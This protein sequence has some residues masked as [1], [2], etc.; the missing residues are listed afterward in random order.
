MHW[1]LLLI[2]AGLVTLIV[3]GCWLMIKTFYWGVDGKPPVYRHPSDRKPDARRDETKSVDS[4]RE[5]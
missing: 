2:L 4:A 3:V 5:R 1:E